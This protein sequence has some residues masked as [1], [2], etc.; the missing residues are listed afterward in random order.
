MVRHVGYD[1]LG[2]V[3]HLLTQGQPASR[4]M[5][6]A[7]ELHIDFLRQSLIQAGIPFVEVPPRPEGAAFVCCL[8]HD[9]DFFGIR[10]HRL[11]ST[12]AGFFA[13]GSLGTLIDLLRG[14]R[15]LAEA[16]RNWIA[17][18]SVPLVFLRLLP[19]FWRPVD[20][21]RAADI[22][23]ATFFVVPFKGRC[24]MGPD[25]AVDRKRAVPYQAS[26][27]RADLLGA[28]ARGQEIG[29]HGIDA[30]RGEAE[31]RAESAAIASAV[32][33]QPTGV[34]MH[35]LYFSPRS[36]EHLEAA[37]FAYDSTWGYNDAVGYRAGTSQVFRFPTTRSLLELPLSIMDSALFYRHRMHLRHDEALN[38]CREIIENA[39]R[40]GGT[41]V[42][43]WH[44]RSLAPE[45]LWGRAY[46]EL[47][48]ALASPGA[49]FATAGEAVEWFRWRRSI[50]F[51]E[52]D[53]GAAVTMVAS[54][55]RADRPAVVLVHNR[56]AVG[57]VVAV[58]RLCFDGRIPLCVK[59]A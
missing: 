33:R 48:Q 59:F 34:R 35:W 10:R 14:R 37:G 50:R 52:S 40:F 49:W 18:L 12:L 8:T 58:E 36:P 55:P 44:D 6:P 39:R 2:E 31:G 15:S 56:P 22:E 13:R 53:G 30:W 51:S 21:Y 32:G 43:N 7:L 4:A 20:E 45:R 16:L 46:H 19:D 47:Q 27:V 29:L 54:G 3:R 23:R 24:G 26:E 42:V 17:V 9:L 38:I 41:V 1:L 57:P 5:I 11:D 25:G 28:M